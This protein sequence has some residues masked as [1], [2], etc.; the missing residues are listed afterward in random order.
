MDYVLCVKVTEKQT[1][2]RSKGYKTDHMD[3]RKP[4]LHALL[5]ALRRL[6]GHIDT[7]HG[8]KLGFRDVQMTVEA[9][10]FTPLRDDGKV[11]LGHV[12]HEQQDVDVAGFPAGR[13]L[14]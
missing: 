4:G 2:K 9:A 8:V 3:D 13:E 10:A 14:P 11:G 1:W 6:P 5:H 7:T 12:A